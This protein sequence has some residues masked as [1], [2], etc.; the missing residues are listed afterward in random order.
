MLWQGM[1]VRGDWSIIFL[2]GREFFTCAVAGRNV[3]E[4]MECIGVKAL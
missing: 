1:E 2:W 3:R 4:G